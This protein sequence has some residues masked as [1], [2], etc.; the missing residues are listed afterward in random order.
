MKGVNGCMESVDF[1]SSQWKD[2]EKREL[3]EQRCAK[4]FLVTVAEPL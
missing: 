3:G 1:L 2:A 4:V